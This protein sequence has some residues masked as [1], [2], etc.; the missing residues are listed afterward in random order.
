MHTIRPTRL[1]IDLDAICNNYRALRAAAGG[2]PALAVVKA[3][4]KAAGA[5]RQSDIRHAEALSL[6]ANLRGPFDLVLLDPPFHHGLL[7]QVLPALQEKVAPGGVI[8]AESERD[9]ELPEQVGCLVRTKQYFYG[10]IMVSRYE[11]E[12]QV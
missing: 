10:K 5:D 4:C 2:S 7:A 11:R 8:L 1:E 6:L 3:N 9:A 12:G